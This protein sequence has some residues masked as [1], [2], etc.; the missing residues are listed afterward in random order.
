M[1]DICI[2]FIVLV[3][4]VASCEGTGDCLTRTGK[5]QE[6]FREVPSFNAIVM[7]EDINLKL[8]PD[9]QQIVLMQA[10]KN[11]LPEISTQVIDGTL[12]IH[13]GNLCR[14]SRSYAYQ[15]TAE[16]HIQNLARIDNFGS[17]NLSATAPLTG[18]TFILS[19]GNGTGQ[20][21]LELYYNYILIYNPTGTEDILLQGKT[22]VLEIKNN[23]KGYLDTHGL[24]ADTVR[25]SNTSTNNMYV[26]ANFYLEIENHGPGIVYYCGNAEPI[27][28]NAEAEP[29][30]R[31]K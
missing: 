12:H 14:W 21:S 22:D 4:L 1:K 3:L 9:T 7:N 6:Q 15:I 19:V 27:F 31:R 26:R 28:I 2:L 23:A 17:G 29:L 20:T 11:L 24:E 30:C 5:L 18:T 10:G 13:N 16:A 25:I 8:V